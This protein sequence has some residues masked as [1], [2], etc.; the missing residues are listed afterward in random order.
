MV[1][2]FFF[3]ACLSL[4]TVDYLVETSTKDAICGV[5]QRGDTRCYTALVLILSQSSS[6][7]ETLD[8]FNVL[9]VVL[10]VVVVAVVLK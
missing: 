5:A 10:F 1:F 4:G 7:H 6:S 3:K 2:L 8:K 9:S